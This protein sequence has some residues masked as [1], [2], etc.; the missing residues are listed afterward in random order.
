MLQIGRIRLKIQKT[1][2]FQNDPWSS[3]FIYDG[4]QHETRSIPMLTLPEKLKAFQMSYIGLLA[5][6]GML[7]SGK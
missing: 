3:E 5:C 4:F 2:V 7:K 6:S 1:Q